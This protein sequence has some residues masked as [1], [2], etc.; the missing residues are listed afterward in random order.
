MP[1]NLTGNTIASTYDQLLHV[2][3]GPTATE[4]IVYSGTGVATAMQLGTVSASVGNVQLTGNTIQALT[5]NLTLGSAIAFASASNARTALGLGTIATQ[6]A[7]NV[8]ITGGSI[9]GVSFTGSFTGVTS[10]E[11]GTFAT[12]ATAA[13]S[14]LSG[15]TL[16]ADGTDT[17]INLNITPKGTGRTIVG[18]LTTTSPRILTGIN[19]TN[20]NELMK[21]TAV[22]FAV[23]EL[24][25]ANAATGGNPTIT[26]TG[27]DTDISISIIPK[28]SGSVGIS[29]LTVLSLRIALDIRDAGGLPVLAFAGVASAVNRLGITNA[30]TGNGPTLTVS[31]ADTN[32]DINI[33]PKGT[34]EVNVTNIDVLSGKVPFNTITNRAYASFYDAN[35]TDQTGSTTDRT[36][37]K[38]ATAAVTG[39]GITVASD[40]RITLAVAGTYRI[41]ASLQ[42]NNSVNS[43]SVV[44]V[45]FA[46][47]GTNIASSAAK[48]TVPKSSEGGTYL[49]AYEIFETV[50]ANDY[51]EMFWYPDNVGTTL[52][53]IAAIASNPGVTP[54]IPIVPPAI[55]VVER[56]A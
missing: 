55:V 2:D 31:G 15:N 18:A 13:G 16:A 5:G 43:A 34:G 51:I 47:N 27:D 20:G 56:V 32:I 11:A 54:A 23:N 14:N 29:G 50:A 22:A 38:W 26:A 44:K 30:A 49:A 45:W 10:I 40:S 28:G 53:Y 42:F 39:A 21:V 48:L 9:S 41:N 46:K 17:N 19:D 1:T 8:S 4:K 37:V 24:T 12:S 25:L 35:T 7:N 33:T 6:N 36:A 3:D 52:H